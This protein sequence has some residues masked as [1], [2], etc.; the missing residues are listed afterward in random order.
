MMSL[1]A[2]LAGASP[3][4]CYGE[5]A[6]TLAF[7]DD[8]QKALYILAQSTPSKRDAD[9]LRFAQ[10]VYPHDTESQIRQRGCEVKARI[11]SMAKFAD[12]G[13]LRV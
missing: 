9:Y 2:D 4:Y 12:G 13:M 8:V 1:P 11:K 10:S 5:K 6:F 3:R 7:G